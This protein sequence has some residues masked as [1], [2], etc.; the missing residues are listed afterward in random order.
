MTELDLFYQHIPDIAEMIVNMQEKTPEQ[1]EQW[2]NDC[3]EY[4]SGLNSFVY[5]FMIKTFIVVDKYL[6]TIDEER[7]R[8]RMNN[9]D[10]AIHNPKQT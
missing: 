4:A 7:K 3:L 8:G 10:I 5:E 1:R 9:C 6:K 2:K